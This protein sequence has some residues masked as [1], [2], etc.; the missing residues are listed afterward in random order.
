[1]S[2]PDLSVL[3]EFRRQ[4]TDLGPAACLPQA[5][6]DDWLFALMHSADAL[7]AGE[8]QTPAGA[9]ALA[10]VLT[11]L[12]GTQRSHQVLNADGLTQV[13]IFNDFRI[14]LAM[15]LAHRRTDAQYEAATLQT[16]FTDRDVFI[17][18]DSSARG[19]PRLSS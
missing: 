3:Y 18:R 4:V 7:I 11:I 13:K 9:L 2:H 14:E 1:L 17:W 12:G 8:D 6:S 19:A 16:I 5:L 15:E 10:A